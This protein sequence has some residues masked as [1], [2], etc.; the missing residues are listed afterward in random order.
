MS[1]GKRLIE[2]RKLYSLTQDDL[3]SILGLSRGAVGMYETD[4]REPYSSILVKISN[5]FNIPIDLLLS[6]EKT[7]IDSKIGNFLFSQRTISNISLDQM[8][9]STQINQLTL[10]MIEKGNYIPSLDILE[11]IAINGLGISFSMFLVLYANSLDTNIELSED[12]KSYTS[13][14]LSQCDSLGEKLALLRKSKG[15]TQKQVADYLQISQSSYARFEYNE[16]NPNNDN[17][18]DLSTLFDIPLSLFSDYLET[19][20][21]DLSELDPKSADIIKQLYNHLKEN[22]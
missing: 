11:N 13:S 9:K 8:S 16:V 21:L 19:E 1:I 2:L 17:L 7:S 6:S 15:F 18:K 5:H 10:S 3:A 12:L 4:R 20:L 22:N 14:D